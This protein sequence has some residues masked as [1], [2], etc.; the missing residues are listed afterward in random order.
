MLS[1]GLQPCGTSSSGWSRLCQWTTVTRS[2]RAGAFHRSSWRTRSSKIGP[3]RLHADDGA[4]LRTGHAG[5]GCPFS[6]ASAQTERA[7]DW[8]SLDPRNMLGLPLPVQADRVDDRQQGGPHDQAHR[9]T[10]L[11]GHE[12]LEQEGD[13]DD[14]P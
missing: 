10:K 14:A 13:H 12:A 1:T 3:V 4:N 5:S 11:D 9:E 8:H 2:V 7:Q 6:W